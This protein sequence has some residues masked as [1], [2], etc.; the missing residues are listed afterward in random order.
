MRILKF[1][2]DRVAGVDA[3]AAGDAFVLQTLT[4]IDTG[5]T[6]L[7]AQ[8][9]INA[10]TQLFR[11]RFGIGRDERYKS[12]FVEV[13]DGQQTTCTFQYAGQAAFATRA[14]GFATQTVIGN[15]QR[16]AVKHRALKTGIGAHV[17]T[18]LLT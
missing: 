3:G 6:H 17:F 15:N 14:P 4:N 13:I 1:I 16:I 11:S 2:H 9:A 10:V 18:D 5:G 8:R 7:N 12:L